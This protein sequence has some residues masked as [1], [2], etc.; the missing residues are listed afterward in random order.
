MVGRRFAHQP[1]KQ[2]LGFGRT[3][4]AQINDKQAA[5]ELKLT[6]CGASTNWY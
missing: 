5:A 4:T 1:T 6:A 2:G 3:A